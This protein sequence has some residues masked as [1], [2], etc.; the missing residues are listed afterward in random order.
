MTALH[1]KDNTYYRLAGNSYD[2]KKFSK[3]KIKNSDGTTQNFKIQASRIDKANGFQAMALSP[4]D[5]NGKVDNDTV[6][7]VYAGTEPKEPA[8]IGTDVKLGLSGIFDDQIKTNPK[9]VKFYDEYQDLSKKPFIMN[10]PIGSMSNRTGRF[11][12]RY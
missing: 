10:F 5:S 11:K 9:D 1:N 4:I 6:Y 3:N 7:M 2:T 8:D 12:G